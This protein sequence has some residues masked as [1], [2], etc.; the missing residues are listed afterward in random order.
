MKLVYIAGPYRGSSFLKQE[1][2]IAAARAFGAQ[3][4]ALGAMPVIPHTNTAHFDELAPA[5]FWLDGTLEM[6]RRCDAVLAMPN[7]RQ[8][9]GARGEIA[10]AERIGIPVFFDLEV[11]G[12]WVRCE[13]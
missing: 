10:E 4:P 2:N 13:S 1:Q 5:Q 3:V 7:W 12:V 9:E 6:M 11:L 8:S